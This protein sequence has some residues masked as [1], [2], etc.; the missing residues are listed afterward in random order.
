M[1]VLFDWVRKNVVDPREIV[2]R[3]RM[4]W[5]LVVDVALG[6]VLV[7]LSLM[8]QDLGYRIDNTSKLIE[9]LDL[10]H[11]ELEAEMA[12]ESSPE[13][14]RRIAE[15]KLGLGVAKPGQVVSFDAQP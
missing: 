13:R 1:S 2:Q 3:R 7:W 15:S 14:L 9:K 4:R 8:V 12:A 10:E 11:A 6:L 5:V